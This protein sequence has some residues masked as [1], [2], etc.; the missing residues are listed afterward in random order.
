MDSERSRYGLVISALGAVLLAV[1]VFLPWYGLSF[2][3]AGVALVQ[4]TA[5][6]LAAQY[7]NAA[8]QGYLAAQHAGVSGLAGHEFTAVSAHQVLRNLDI[9]LLVL[10]GLALLDALIPLA[11]SSSS[12]PGGGG[13]AVVLLGAIACVCVVYRMVHPPSPG[14]ELLALSLREGAWLALLGSC[15]VVAGGLWPRGVRRAVTQDAVEEDPWAA[16]SGWTPQS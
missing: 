16:L 7:G 9:V 2:T 15:T 14:G 6:Q 11:T 12:A 4:Q 3:T 5:D 13:A 1:S 10:A 8:I